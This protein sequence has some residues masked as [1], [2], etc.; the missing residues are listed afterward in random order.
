MHVDVKLH[1]PG[2]LRVSEGRG[3]NWPDKL[4]PTPGMIVTFRNSHGTPQS[5]ELAYV[6]VNVFD[7]TT[8]LHLN[9]VKVIPGIGVTPPTSG[10]PLSRAT[11]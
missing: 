7:G 4:V 3:P 2:T 5:G 1:E 6:E 10:Q 9:P 11:P 8:T